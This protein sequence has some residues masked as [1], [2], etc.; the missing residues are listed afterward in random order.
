MRPRRNARDFMSPGFRQSTIWTAPSRTSRCWIDDLVPKA[1][2]SR[3]QSHTF[4]SAHL[5]RATGIEGR[6]LAEVAGELGMTRQAA[7]MQPHDATHYIPGLATRV[8]S[9]SPAD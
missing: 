4:L 6:P 1:A 7:T 5:I 9:A 2:L 3:T 8:G